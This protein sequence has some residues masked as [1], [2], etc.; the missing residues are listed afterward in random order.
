MNDT[1]GHWLVVEGEANRHRNNNLTISHNGVDLVTWDMATGEMTF[2]DTYTPEG[3][4]KIFWDA[5]A[6]DIERRVVWVEEGKCWMCGQV[7]P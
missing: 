4:A 7:K 6:T 1:G 3:A 2:G 5:M